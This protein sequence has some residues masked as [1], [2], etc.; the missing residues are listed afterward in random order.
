MGWWTSDNNEETRVTH[1]RSTESS[2]TAGSGEKKQPVFLEDVPPKFGDDQLLRAE[3]AKRKRDARMPE[4]SE[5]YSTSGEVKRY[6]STLTMD[7]FRFSN[8]IQIPCFRDAGLA[9]FS[10]MFVFSTVMFFYHRNIRKSINWGYGGL[11]LGSV[12]GWEHC[13]R[14]RKNSERVVQLAQERYQEK[15]H[16]RRSDSPPQEEKKSS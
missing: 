7:D 2:N 9:G 6:M 14:V 11:L 15:L 5:H 4:K 8:L 16:K 13:N 1:R 3:E 12:F 10:C